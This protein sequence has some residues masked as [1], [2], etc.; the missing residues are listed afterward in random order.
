MQMDIY[1]KKEK[2][3]RFGSASLHRVI[4]DVFR[5]IFV[6]EMQKF[7]VFSRNSS[8][9]LLDPNVNDNILIAGYSRPYNLMVFY[10]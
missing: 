7:R 3:I 4:N 8:L 1:I 5:I 2:K 6:T 10:L 9:I